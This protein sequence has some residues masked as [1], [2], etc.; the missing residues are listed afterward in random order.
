VDPIDEAVVARPRGPLRGLVHEH[1]GYRQ[2]GVAPARHLG[3]PSP[4]LTVIFT[5]DE[6][7]HIAQPVD[8]RRR[9]GRYEALVGGL[10]DRPAVIEHDGAQSG[11]QLRVSP[12]AAR[13]LLGCPGGE[14]AGFDGHAEDVLGPVVGELLDRLRSA[15]GWSTRFPVVDD[16][17]GRIARPPR[18]VPPEVEH[19][20]RLLLRS[21]GRL[22][23]GDLARTV[24]WSE[25]HLGQRFVEEIG[26]APKT[27]ARVIRFQHARERLQR[28]VRCGRP[29]VAGVAAATGYFDQAHLVRDWRRFTGLAPTQWIAHEFRNFQAEPSS[30]TPASTA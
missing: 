16:V 19:A 5:L 20:W 22:A 25:R 4:F 7:L 29:D 24:G 15:T 1:H 13:S 9:P 23:I 26:L 17:L 18:G 2:R 27:A 21:G 11:I 8:P 10:H 6:P 12:L 14:L 28:N 3:L 30:L